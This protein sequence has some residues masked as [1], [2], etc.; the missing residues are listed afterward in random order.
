M[1]GCV[2]LVGALEG[3]LRVD[4]LVASA[5]MIDLSLVR[6]PGLIRLVARA[7]ARLGLS[8]RLVPGGRLHSISTEPFAGNRL[9]G[10]ERRYARNAAVAR[11]LGPAAIGSPTLGWLVAAYEA[12]ARLAAA[13]CASRIR[14]PT[15]IIGAG[16]DPVC[17]TPAAERF[18]RELGSDAFV[19]IP[20]A[21]HEVMMESDGIRAAF[22]RAFDGFVPGPDAPRSAGQEAKHVVVQATVA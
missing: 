7:L 8:G 15:L 12:M 5:P 4:R 19:L 22:W 20:G 9:C 11:A 2:A 17:S 16:D 21:R 18:A 1:G 13:G 6:W 14:V 3:W 10:D